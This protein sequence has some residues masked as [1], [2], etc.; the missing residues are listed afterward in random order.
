[1]I[2]RASFSLSSIHSVASARQV[3]E[4]WGCELSSS[5][6]KF[7]FEPE[8]EYVVHLLG[9]WTICLGDAEDKTHVIAVESEQTH[10][11]PVPIA[12]LHPSLL[13]MVNIHGLEITPPVTFLLTSGSGP[14]YISGQHV[15]LEDNLDFSQEE[16]VHLG[17]F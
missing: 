13:P 9:L 12:S 11:Q 2:S 15:T 7:L 5:C 17:P 1:M 4:I 14:V 8:D 10:G 6:R 3:C 16:S